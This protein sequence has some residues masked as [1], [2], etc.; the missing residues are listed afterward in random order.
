[1]HLTCSPQLPAEERRRIG[2]GPQRVPTRASRRRPNSHFLARLT[3]KRWSA[4]VFISVCADMYRKAGILRLPTSLRKT[5]FFPHQLRKE[6]SMFN[7][8]CGT[9]DEALL[10]RLPALKLPERWLN[11]FHASFPPVQPSDDLGTT[12]MCCG[13][14]F[15]TTMVVG[16]R[17]RVLLAEATGLPMGFVQLVCDTADEDWF[18]WSEQIVVLDESLRNNPKD[19]AGI[20]AALSG[21]ME[22]F[23]LEVTDETFDVRLQT[24]RGNKLV[25]G[26]EQSWESDASNE[27]Q[28]FHRDPAPSLATNRLHQI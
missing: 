20:D 18:W 11:S 22:E 4:P 5:Y 24:L 28:H 12:F 3:P 15:L 1:M 17:D 10:R 25:G 8:P 23:W 16:T 19:L 6:D 13:A 21:V 14:V 27:G 7:T 26:W 2:V 9:E